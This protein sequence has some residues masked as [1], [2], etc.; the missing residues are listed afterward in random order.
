MG[1]LRV[2]AVAQVFGTR[3][4]AINWYDDDRTIRV[5]RGRS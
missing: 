2:R 1:A 3:I 5:F 4:E